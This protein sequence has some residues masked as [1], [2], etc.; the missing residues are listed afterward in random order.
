MELKSKNFYFFLFF[1]LFSLFVQIA[2]S[3]RK[4]LKRKRVTIKIKR[5]FHIFNSTKY[6]SLVVQ[7]PRGKKTATINFNLKKSNKMTSLGIINQNFALFSKSITHLVHKKGKSK[8]SG[9]KILTNQLSS[10]GKIEFKKVPQWRLVAQD[11]WNRNLTA[12]GWNFNMI[13]RCNN[14]LI[15]GGQCLLSKKEISKEYLNL[16]EHKMIRI[17]AFFHHIGKWNSNSGYLRMLDTK[18]ND[19][20]LWTNFCKNKQNSR[21]N[22]LCGYETCKINVPISV[23][24]PHTKNR[25]SIAFGADL[26]HDHPCEGS[27]AVSDIKIYLR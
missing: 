2:R 22:N 8:I 4:L 13:S 21:F 16:P 18:K 25:F 24:I 20:F 26:N 11:T 15:L 3:E 6:S 1:L 5:N 23:T 19:K 9:R 27:Y 7:A 17:E 14:A 10:H 12:N